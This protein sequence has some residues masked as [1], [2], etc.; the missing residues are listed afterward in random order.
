[1][2][3]PL[4]TDSLGDADLLL[5][6]LRDVSTAN[7]ADRLTQAI[8]QT[9]TRLVGAAFGAFFYN[10]VSPQGDSYMLY[11]LAGLP[12]D[13]FASFPMPRKT[14]VFGV[15]FRGESV[16]R[17]DDVTQDVR[18]GHNT[19]WKG[20]PPGHPPV[21]SYLALPVVLH[22]GQ[23]LGGLFFGHPEAA[24]FTARHE[25][26]ASAVSSVAAVALDGLRLRA[27][28]QLDEERYRSLADTMAQLVWMAKPDGNIYWYNNRWYEYTGMTPDEV[29]GW[30]WQQ[31]HDPR[32][33][34][35]VLDP[36]EPIDRH[37]PTL[38]NDVSPAR[39]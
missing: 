21:R 12:S 35:E 17:L 10:T 25:Q 16:L 7:D 37:R 20:M 5:G 14:D 32:V 11:S 31:V 15:T 1:M 4:D 29:Y 34:P 38:R 22:N 13:A 18:Y 3:D 28:V 2:I 19:P 36:L 8:T 39:P 24:R 27:Q 6:L 23:V 30:G 26:L 9:L 33:L